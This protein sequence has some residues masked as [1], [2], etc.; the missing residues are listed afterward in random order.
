L[1]E[2]YP[3]PGGPASTTIGA[4]LDPADGAVTVTVV[5][6]ATLV[7]CVEVAVTVT[8]VFEVTVGAVS[9]P[10]GEIVPALAVQ[11]TPVLKLPVPPTT[12]VHWVEAPELIVLGE[13]LTVTDVTLEELDPP[14]PPQAAKP[15][16]LPNASNSPNLRIITTF[17][18]QRISLG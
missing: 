13:Q 1:V 10:P 2:V 6:P 8:D 9:R 17:L 4:T 7:F 5:V 3:K 12:A 14:L 15:M 16:M 11:V 18:L